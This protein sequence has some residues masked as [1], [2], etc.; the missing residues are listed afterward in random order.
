MDREETDEDI[1]YV[2]KKY[3]DL[4]LRFCAAKIRDVTERWDIV[5]RVFLDYIQYGKSFKSEEHRGNWLFKVTANKIGDFLRDYYRRSRNE[6]PLDSAREHAAALDNGL[7]LEEIR[8]LPQKQSETIYLYYYQGYSIK[9]ISVILGVQPSTV[10]NNLL[11]GR[12]NLKN[13]FSR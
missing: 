10:K 7:F 13:I 4:L 6:I 3:T 11:K 8:R 5:Q 12:E 2:V 1:D 9:E